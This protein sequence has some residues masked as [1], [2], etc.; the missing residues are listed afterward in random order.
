M[1]EQL[2]VDYDRYPELIKEV[3]QYVTTIEDKATVAVLHSMIAEMYMSYYQQNQWQINRRT[4]ISDYFPD[5][6]REWTANLFDEKVKEEL[7]LSLQSAD[8]LQRTSVVQYKEILTEGK[9]SPQLRPTLYDFLM[10][11]ALDMKPSDEL[12]TDLLNFRR[13]QNN[14]QATLFVELAYL[15]YQYGNKSAEVLQKVYIPALDNLMNSYKSEAY[16]IEIAIEKSSVLER[17]QYYVNNQDSISALLYKLYTENIA[18]FPSYERTNVLKNKLLSL[19]GPMFEFQINNTIYPGTPIDLQVNYKNLKQ[20]KVQVYESKRALSELTYYGNSSRNNTKGRLVKEISFALNPSASYL[21]YDS[22]LQFPSLPLGLY[23]FVVTAPGESLQSS[24]WSS[25]TKLAAVFRDSETKQTEVLVTD[26]QTG[27]PIPNAVVTWYGEQRRNLQRLGEVK[28]DKDGIAL[29]PKDSKAMAMNATLAGDTAMQLSMLYVA[30]YPQ[31][32]ENIP[33]TISLFTDR[34]LY[35]PGQQLFFKGIAYQLQKDKQEVV[36]NRTVKVILR[37]ANYK[38]VATKSFTTNEFGSFNGE[39]TLPQQGLNG[40]Y[41]LEADNYSTSLRVEEYKRPTFAV[42]FLPITSEIAFGDEVPLQGKVQ[43]F[44]GVALTDGK[45]TWRVVRRPFWLRIG[46]GSFKTEQVAEGETVVSADGTFGFSFIPQ[47]EEIRSGLR[48]YYTYEVSAIITDS[49][50]ETQ[51]GSSVF[52]VGDTGI[53]L[54]TDSPEKMEKDSVSFV[55]KARTLNGESVAAT[56]NY[57]IAVLED[58]I[59][60]GERTGGFNEGRTVGRGEFTADKAFDRSV[61]STL[62]SGRYRVHL[63]SRDSKGRKVTAEQDLIVYSKQDK[64]PPVYSP[65]WVLEEKTVCQ[66]GENVQFV[67]G[68]S[69]KDAYILYELYSN[70]K[71]IVRNRIKL[72]NENRVFTLPFEPSWGDGAVASFV[73]I[74]EGKFHATNVTIRKK[75]PN[76]Q[77]V[78]KP[79]TFRDYLLPGSKEN[80]QFRIWNADSTAVKAE[81]L[82]GMYDA[83]L[84]KIYPFD[85]SFAP[86][87]SVYLR[88]PGFTTGSGFRKNYGGDTKR[89]SYLN[90]QDFE[91]SNLDWQG[92]LSGG[93]FGVYGSANYMN[94]SARMMMKSASPDMMVAEVES[95]VAM[96]D[97][98]VV[99]EEATTTGGDIMPT[100]NQASPQIR[101]N[102]NETAF[103]YPTLRTNETGDVLLNFTLPESNTTWKLQ[104]VAHTA[105]LYFGQLKQEIIASKPLMVLPNLPRFLRQ[106]DNV[107]VSTQL[108]SQS[109]EMLNGKVNLVFFD[110]ATDRVIESMHTDEQSFRLD[111]KGSAVAS[112]TISVPQGINLIGCRIVA[113]ADGVSDGEQHLLPVLSDQILIT[114]S[115]PFFLLNEGEKQLTTGIDKPGRKPFRLTLEMTGNPVWYAVQALP[116]LTQPEHDN[117]LSWFAV[118]YSNILATH[119]ANAHP[120]IQQVI[121]QW[122]TQGG[123]A[124]TLLSNLERNEELKNILLEETP[125]VLEAQNET[126]QKQRLSLLFDLNRSSY[127]YDTALQRLI[128]QQNEDGG[129]SWYKGFYSDRTMTLSILRGMAQLVELNAIQYGEQE[130]RMQMNALRFLD[131]AIRKDYEQLKKNNREWEKARPTSGQ[132]SY[133]Y[134]RSAYRDIPESVETREASRFYTDQAEKQW[135]DLSLADK[136]ALAILLHRNGKKEVAAEIMAWFRRTATT[137]EEMGMYWANNRRGA[138]YFTSPID[139]HSLLMSAFKE[140]G[141]NETEVNRMKQWLLSQKRTQN[142]ESTPSTVNAIYAILLSGDDWLSQNNV[143]TAQWN[144]NRYS[145]ADGE[146]ATGYLKEVLTAEAINPAAA[147]ITIRKE[148]S[149]PVWGAVYS[150][151]FESLDKVSASKGVLNVEKK[152]FV[153]INN[154]NEIQI[155][156]VTSG[157]PL[158]VGDKVIVRLTIRTDRDMD[159]VFLKDLRAGC[160]EPGQSLSGYRSGD[161]VGYYQS[162]KDVAEH[163]FFARLP[164]GTFVVEYPV[165]VSRTGEYTAGISTIQCMY[166]PEFVSHTDGEKIVVK[167]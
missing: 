28:T 141:S 103:F 133:L 29:L 42:D 76:K 164:K 137:S 20:L 71:R 129:W 65:F 90:Y 53:L 37:D 67:V 144:G 70:G 166:A 146:V 17:T 122:M 8:L 84:D 23:E 89:I 74:K 106:G 39:F 51:E 6:I 135:K 160:F 14:R 11:R 24:Q 145:T 18:R 149:T 100:D 56:G 159:Y 165:Y 154:G 130:K 93:G 155:R 36:P 82:A 26:Y 153:E 61:F 43:T 102:F 118:Y 112:W 125:W 21:T 157:Q 134:V 5:D 161:G 78:V 80:W 1:K 57:T 150:Q 54:L 117:V 16:S 123:D 136:A 128:E 126:E 64:Q 22:V 147:R 95:M 94:G 92:M 62:A 116:T 142:W 55:V 124:T 49:K 33:T 48:D 127:M 4:N 87:R 19:E 77:L 139:V 119:I 27:K 111:A 50:G 45:V 167:E 121:S 13:S 60:K 30:D 9:D 15:Q 131:D 156:P 58:V 113:E 34:G 38:E 75:Q 98:A 41:T 96:D 12:Y 107:T 46:Y 152:L 86:Q 10:W 109:E 79:I 2:E 69:E 115:K 44:S 81:L 151:Y 68:T 110:P 40:Y 59:E 47:K 31:M 7:S 91:F 73:F 3:E 101:Q 99:E 162:P 88:A 25:V 158:R 114:E 132:I 72:N 35:R 63:E 105:D 66:P 108:L 85:W 138:D 83:S 163:F 104:L 52:S 143:V 140:L 148:G 32:I 97:M 120:R